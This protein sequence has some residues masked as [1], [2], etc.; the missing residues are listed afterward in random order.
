MKK[1]WTLMAMVAVFASCSQ[2]EADSPLNTYT[3]TGYADVESR[4]AF[5]TPGTNKIP[6]QWSSGD[7]IYVGSTKSYAISNGG[8]SANFTIS[9]TPSSNE[10]YYNI[11]G[12]SAKE[13]YVKTAQTVGNL[14]TNG[15]FGYGTI[16]N[17]SFKLNHATSY[18]WFDITSSHSSN[19]TL[20]SVKVSADVNIAGKATWNGSSFGSISEGN[21]SIELT[22]NQALSST[23]NNVWAMVVLP[24]LASKS[25]KVT[26]KLN[27]GNATKYYSETITGKS[28]FTSGKTQKVSLKITNATQLTDYAELRV[29][30]FEDGSEKFS[31]YTIISYCHDTYGSGE[32]EEAVTYTINKWSNLIPEQQKGDPLNYGST[33]TDIWSVPLKTD[34][35]WADVNNTFLKHELRTTEVDLDWDGIPDAECKTYRSGGHSIS[36]HRQTVTD[37][38]T[39]N[40]NSYDWSDVM[41]SIPIAPRSGTNFCVH[42]GYHNFDDEAESLH[43]ITFSDDIPRV[44]DY[45]WV[46]N[47]SYVLHSLKYG[48]Q[49]NIDGA[50]STTD[51]W[52]VATG[53]NGTTKTGQ[54]SVYLCKQGNIVEDW[55]KFELKSLGKVTSI[56]FNV[57]GS[58]D[59]SGNYGLN[60]PAYFAYDD[61]AVQF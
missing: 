49:F 17:G 44:V 48:D 39:P 58:D 53:Y 34:Y 56:K 19:V 6:F 7:Y 47:T 59:Q 16:S 12:T 42:N 13:A 51:F 37:T 11:S 55:I 35:Y 52:I 43:K 14:G 46:T 57:R 23:N 29:L 18:L 22:V 3:L 60:T 26:Y 45:M 24:N 15:D 50:T 8:S 30:T 38:D 36:N 61:V 1:L 32:Y 41:L 40:S 54:V 27:V 10:V 5:G 28:N 21:K 2:E 20:Q 31:P 25:F 33:T 4:T 9:G